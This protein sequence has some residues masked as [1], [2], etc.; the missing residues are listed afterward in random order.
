MLVMAE[1]ARLVGKADST[2]SQLA[3][4]VSKAEGKQIPAEL[5]D[6]A[7]ALIAT[8]KKQEEVKALKE[9]AERI[10]AMTLG[11]LVRSS[12]LTPERFVGSQARSAPRRLIG[13]L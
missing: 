6:R 7:I 11:E 12:E 8:K 5:L 4:S 2:S 3:S 10:V 13:R 1:L 9:K